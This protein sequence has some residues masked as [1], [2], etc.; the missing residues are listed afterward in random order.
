M[1]KKWSRE[2]KSIWQVVSRLRKLSL[3]LPWCLVPSI[4][5][6]LGAAPSLHKS[7]LK[8]TKKDDFNLF[9]FI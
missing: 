9:E 3:L 7:S 6:Q 1:V 8:N 4:A 5:A 2:F